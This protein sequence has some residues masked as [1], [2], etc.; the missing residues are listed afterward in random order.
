MFNKI[1]K[2]ANNCIKALTVILLLVIVLLGAM[3]V[4]TMANSYFP[5]DGDVVTNEQYYNDVVDEDNYTTY[6]QSY[7]YHF[8]NDDYIDDYEY[9]SPYEDSQPKYG[10]EE[11]YELDDEDDYGLYRIITSITPTMP[12]IDVIIDGTESFPL[13]VADGETAAI[14]GNI[15]GNIIVDGGILILDYN[16]TITGTITVRNSGTFI[17]ES[18]TITGAGTR[19][20]TV[21]DAGSAFVMS[22]GIIVGNTTTTHGGGVAVQNGA[23]FT[24][25]GTALIYNNEATLN[26]GGVWINTGASFE[27]SGTALINDNQAFANG[28]GVHVS[29]DTSFIMVGGTIEHN[30]AMNGGGVFNIG[31]FTMSGKSTIENNES[32]ESAGSGSGGGV[33]NLNRFYMNGGIIRNNTTFANNGGGI[34][35]GSSSRMYMTD[36][37]IVGNTT[38]MDG[39]GINVSSDSILNMSGGIIGGAGL[40]A[41]TAVNGGGINVRGNGKFY[42]SDNALIYGNIASR[43]GGGVHVTNSDIF[44]MTGGTIEGNTAIQSGGGVFVTGANSEFTMSGGTIEGNTATLDGGG[45]S[46]Q[47]GAGIIMTGTA[48]VYDN[49][50]RLGGGVHITGT[51]ATFTMTNGA[52][53]GNRAVSNGG[54]IN[55]NQGA[56]MVMNGGLIEGNTAALGGAIDV[57]SSVATSSHFYM[58][59]PSIIYNNTATGALGG[60]G[61][62]VGANAGGTHGGLFTMTGGIIDYNHATNGNGGGVRV[63]VNR[64]F[65]MTG[66]TISRN[67]AINGGGVWVGIDATFETEDGQIISNTAAQYGG[68]IWAAQYDSLNIANTVIFS[69]NTANAPYDYGIAN[70][71]TLG[72]VPAANSGGGQGGNPQNIDWSTVSILGTH[73]LNNFDINYTGTPILFN[74]T[75]VNSHATVTGAGEYSHGNPVTIHAGTRSGY[76]FAGWTIDGTDVVLASTTDAT[77]TFTMPL[78]NVTVTA[79]WTSIPNHTVTFLPG[80]TIGVTGMP[81]NRVVADGAEIFTAGGVVA[82]PSRDGYVFLGWLQTIP[83]GTGVFISSVNVGS[84]VVTQDIT[85]VAQWQPIGN[86][87]TS[88]YNLVINKIADILHG[89]HVIVGGTVTY[90]ISVR[91]SGIMASGSVD[92]TDDIPSGM[93]FVSGSA[94]TRVNGAINTAIVPVILGNRLT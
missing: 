94:V 16:W 41:N 51:S 60:G 34:H 54:G 14:A 89:S 83:T 39:G 47:N 66:G 4:R 61:V 28:G 18:G 40:E 85:F 64:A 44:T 59:E 9:N 91:N 50:G 17:M 22:S 86:G 33:H 76:T 78:R 10:R 92:I 27:M 79:N 1:S 48:L 90:T 43:S 26:G 23:A 36:G 45:I 84:I 67:T 63:P 46:V 65:T 2:L 72:N 37:T 7:N 80:A 42:M 30:T 3:P 55:I 53:K 38:S 15:T 11:D 93:T 70:L 75:V 20:V 74:V 5:F 8:K 69:G 32:N 71:G 29:T 56:V 77:T 73:A 81:S 68:G 19:G 13:T 87:G 52:I 24:M 62:Q 82:T 25:S 58:N 49:T 12:L 57:T 35:L 6:D 21:T 88:N 31:V